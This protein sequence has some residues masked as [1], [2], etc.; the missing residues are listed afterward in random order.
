MVPPNWSTPERPAP[1]MIAPVLISVVIVP[2]KISTPTNPLWV[3]SPIPPLI[4]PLLVS[5]AIVPVFDTPGP[6]DSP[7]PPLP[8]LIV[9]LLVSVAIVPEFVT[10][11]PPKPPP[12]FPPLIVPLLVSAVIVPAF[13]TPAPPAPPKPKGPPFPPVIA[14]LL[15]RVVIVWLF[16]TPMPPGAL[17]APAAALIAPLFVSVEMEQETAS[18]PSG[19]PEMLPVLVTVILPPVLRIGPGVGKTIVWFSPLHAARAAPGA[20]SVASAM[21]EAPAS[22]AARERPALAGVKG[23]AGWGPLCAPIRLQQCLELMTSSP[24][25]TTQRY[26]LWI[27]RPLHIRQRSQ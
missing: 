9:P 24:R 13:D 5:V 14:P 10:P 3:A 19:P 4:V 27:L 2:E 21:S 15:V 22:S 18:T 17:A 12:P 20:A 7:A 8:P 26:V 16:D 23:S 1:P 11:V 25:K 6:P